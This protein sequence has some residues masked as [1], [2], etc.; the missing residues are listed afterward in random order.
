M[1]ANARGPRGS[2]GRW[3]KPRE[4]P[5]NQTWRVFRDLRKELRLMSCCKSDWIQSQMPSAN[6]IGSAI[7]PD[8]LPGFCAT[9]AQLHTFTQRSA[10]DNPI[11][12]HARG[13]LAL[14]DARTPGAACK[15]SPTCN[16]WGLFQ[17][18]GGGTWLLA[19]VPPDKQVPSLAPPFH[20]PSSSPSHCFIPSSHPET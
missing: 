15:L 10:S 9:V 2:Y 5:E 8:T 19:Q 18:D 17:R 1:Q 7:N 6:R 4:A 11:Q 16:Q 3:S 12:M 20:P 14:V 13:L